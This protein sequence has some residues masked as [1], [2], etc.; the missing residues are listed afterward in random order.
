M[1]TNIILGIGFLSIC[2]LLFFILASLFRINTTL[3]IITQVVAVAI[4]RSG[5]VRTPEEVEQ[6]TKAAEE[7]EEESDL[8]L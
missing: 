2:L 6:D 1:I 8:S 4:Q 7:E 5:L 3:N